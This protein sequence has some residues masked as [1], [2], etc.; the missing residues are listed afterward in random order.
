MREGIVLPNVGVSGHLEFLGGPG[1]RDGDHAA[2]DTQMVRLA[3]QRHRPWLQARNDTSFDTAL[4]MHTSYAGSVA[5]PSHGNKSDSLR[6][7]H[8]TRLSNYSGL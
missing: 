3:D 5:G 8:G 6:M 4:R 1:G 2:E 7:G